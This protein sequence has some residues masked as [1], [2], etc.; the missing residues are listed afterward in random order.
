MGLQDDS[1]I[2]E[3]EIVIR[4]LNPVHCRVWDDDLK[5]Y[6]L[7]TA[8][9]SASKEPPHG[10]SVDFLDLIAAAGQDPRKFVP[11]PRFSG[12]VTFTVQ[13][14]RAAGLHLCR[15]PLE[16]TTTEPANPF[17]G[18]VWGSAPDRISRGQRNALL[19][20][21]QWLVQLPEVKIVRPTLP[22]A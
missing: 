6:R 4:R 9:F 19:R 17:H 10:M 13:E 14:A 7:S 22:L 20:V 12:S 3:N 18:E 15:D 1:T 11:N 5:C 8:A 2:A 21:C 16:A